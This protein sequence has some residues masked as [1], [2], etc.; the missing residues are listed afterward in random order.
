MQGLKHK[1]TI[2]KF[3]CFLMILEMFVASPNVA[4]AK[5]EGIKRG[6]L[7]EITVAAN[8]D[9]LTITLYDPS[10]PE[11]TKVV[12]STV[13]SWITV[14][15]T[16]YYSASFTVKFQKNTS[17]SRT[18]T[19]QFT[20]GSYIWYAK[21]TQN[22]PTPTPTPKPKKSSNN[23]S[24]NN[25]P[26]K[27]STPTPKATPVP[28]ST[29]TPMPELTAS[30]A[31][32]GFPAD[33]ATKTV[34]ISGYTGTLRADRNDTWFTVSV[35]GGTISVTA[36]KNTSTARAGYVD[37]TDTGSGRSVRIQ[38]TQAAPIINP[39]PTKA[40]TSTPT[41][42]PAET[43]PVSRKKM[44]IGYQGGQDTLSLEGKN[45]SL[46]FSFSDNTGSTN[47][48]VGMVYD[49]NTI[50]V[51][52]DRNT[53]YSPRSI[54]VKI[55]DSKSNQYAY[56]TISQKAAPKPSPT[57][58][59]FLS[60]SQH[61]FFFDDKGGSDTITLTGVR[62]GISF[63][64]D[65]V[66]DGQKDWAHAIYD[67]KSVKLTVDQSR[68]ID[69]RTALI[70]ITDTS[71]KKNMT[72]AVSQEAMPNT[73]VVLK[74]P[75][76]KGGK[77]VNI[78]VSGDRDQRMYETGQKDFTIA[79]ETPSWISVKKNPD[80]TLTIA[81]EENKT[82]A[83]RKAS[84]DVS[85][86]GDTSGGVRGVATISIT[87]ASGVRLI[88]NYSGCE[89]NSLWVF[90]ELNDTYGTLP[91]PGK[92][93]NFEFDGWYTAADGGTEVKTSTVYTGYPYMLYAH[94][95][96]SV[97]L[98][99]FVD[100][101]MYSYEIP[102][103]EGCIVRIADTYVNALKSYGFQVVG[104][105]TNPDSGLKDN[106]SATE[107][108]LPK[109]L[110]CSGIGLWAVNDAGETV[111]EYLRK[112]TF[113][114]ISS[115]AKNSIEKGIAGVEQFAEDVSYTK[116]EKDQYIEEIKDYYGKKDDPSKRGAIIGV[117]GTGKEAGNLLWELLFKDKDSTPKFDPDENKNVNEEKEE[118]VKEVSADL[119]EYI[120]G[121]R[122]GDKKDIKIGEMTL[123]EAGCGAIACHNALYACGIRSVSLS[124]VIY[125]VEANEYLWGISDRKLKELEKKTRS[126]P[127][128]HDFVVEAAR[129][130]KEK[131]ADKATGLGV[132]P[133][134]IDDI[135]AHYDISCRR[136]M[137]RSSFLG[138]IKYA[139][140]HGLKKKYI[141]D[142]W[143]LNEK[144]QINSMH[145]IYIETTGKAGDTRLK[146]YNYY[147]NSKG[148]E[149]LSYGDLSGELTGPDGENMYLLGFEITE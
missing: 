138:N 42:A 38:V 9:P 141:I 127:E 58:T 13:P 1:R 93:A 14:T 5:S 145:Y 95:K 113:K 111:Q 49:G 135:L 56:V 120:N 36:T 100:T 62:G 27:G 66:T 103:Q 70:I 91:A 118:E 12:S 75:L 19:I 105:T 106:G 45:Y 131:G 107:Y 77:T 133:Y 20:E 74:Y 33:G 73:A 125:Y 50:K 104:W 130:F 64:Y 41:P 63:K 37:V 102:G 55:F 35:S 136:I 90:P 98:M 61:E 23:G 132:N 97:K 124:D 112:H 53:S 6:T 47:N 30:E 86:Q 40:P 18:A 108:R 82:G 128:V 4:E 65:W 22:K 69:P 147:S 129:M 119:D 68:S 67:G 146:V 52:V 123:G 32:L 121:Q 101:K 116:D 122:D 71:T 144:D 115:Q 60:T 137:T 59:P 142:Y 140:N 148:Y 89:E 110:D 25:T 99:D 11:N 126:V 15:K 51:K 81:I 134:Y 94:W 8:E 21:I 3:L 92:R 7:K 149:I 39:G 80:R 85:I 87:Q 109:N 26:S 84:F 88:Q 24:K 10:K 54:K 79:S 28:T 83:I 16:S 72:I 57:P 31:S 76:L 2:A 48:W 114:A 117:V 78:E 143:V 43:L 44:D 96:V 34:T 139:I 29:P 46:T 17:S